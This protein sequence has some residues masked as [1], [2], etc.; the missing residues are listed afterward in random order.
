MGQMGG[1]NQ[2]LGFAKQHFGPPSRHQQAVPRRDRQIFQWQA[3]AKC[4]PVNPDRAQMRASNHVARSQIAPTQPAQLW[5]LVVAGPYHVAHLQL[6]SGNFTA[7][8]Q[9]HG[10]GGK[11]DQKLFDVEISQDTGDS[12]GQG[13]QNLNDAIQW[14]KRIWYDNDIAPTLNGQIKCVDVAARAAAINR[15]A[16]AAE[17]SINASAAQQ[18]IFARPAIKAV[19]A[20][21]AVVGRQCC[22]RLLLSSPKLG[23]SIKRHIFA[24]G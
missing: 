6:F 12:M 1:R 13:I 2:N 19:I 5:Q 11:A 3:M 8:G 21:A 4:S 20:T 18:R 10:P 9:D 14:V 24:W 22:S 17:K 23:Q 15:I 7:L 16:G